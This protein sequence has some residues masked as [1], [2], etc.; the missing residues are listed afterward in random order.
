MSTN[1]SKRDFLK[2]LAVGGA[3]LNAPLV[4]AGKRDDKVGGGKFTH[5]CGKMGN[6]NLRKYYAR[7]KDALV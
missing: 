7:N 3:C 2:S 1:I 6:V 5:K 4:F